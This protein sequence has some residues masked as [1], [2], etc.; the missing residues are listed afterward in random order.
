[1]LPYLVGLPF[2]YRDVWSG[3]LKKFQKSSSLGPTFRHVAEEMFQTC[4]E[5]EISLFAGT[6]RRIWFRRNEVINGGCFLHPIVLLQQV[7]ES[8]K[9]FVEARNNSL[10]LMASS[11]NLVGVVAGVAVWWR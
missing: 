3:S 8:M 7:T 11:Q 5:M 6:T 4:D 10:Q 9:D 2:S 1:M